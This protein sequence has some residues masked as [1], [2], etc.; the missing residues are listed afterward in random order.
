VAA[1]THTNYEIMVID[2]GSTDETADLL[3]TWPHPLQVM[4][5][6]HHGRPEPLRN[7]GLAAAKGEIVAFLDDD[8][9]WQPDYLARQ[10]AHFEAN[11]AV[12]L[13]YCDARFLSADGRLSTPRLEPETK[14]GAKLLDNLLGGWAAHPS[15]ITFRRA[16]L[17]VTGPID[18]TIFTQGD[19][20]FLLRLAYHTTPVCTPEPLA[21]LQRDERGLSVQRDRLH[22]E[23]AITVHNRFTSSHPLTKRQQRL[24]RRCRARWHN[25]LAQFDLAER[26]KTAARTHFRQALSLWPVQRRAWLG[27]LQSLT[28]RAA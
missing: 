5:L 25:H 14:D 19:Y 17:D 2:D 10:S 4:H 22:Y 26:R 20:D 1:Q 18:E 27:L 11:P 28:L 12:G 21:I 15:I 9:Q 13:A 6:P 24:S 8:D 16:L 7:V 3:S 23:N